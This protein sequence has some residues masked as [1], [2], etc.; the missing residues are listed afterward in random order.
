[1]QFRDA[2]KQLRD[3]LGLTQNDLANALCVNYTTVGRWET[4][5]TL[6][7]RSIVSMLIEY[8]KAKPISAECL[9]CLRSSGDNITKE[10]LHAANDKL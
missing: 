3:E 7:N 1:M 8:A 10:K 9:A 5:K 6:P 4:G 2:V